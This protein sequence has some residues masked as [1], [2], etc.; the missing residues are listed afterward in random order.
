MTLGEDADEEDADEED[1]ND[2]SI[3]S[4][5]TTNTNLLRATA[6]IATAT[7]NSKTT[8]LVALLTLSRTFRV[9]SLST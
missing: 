4:R 8:Y 3:A 5:A 6:A 2:D 1:A 7:Y 9:P